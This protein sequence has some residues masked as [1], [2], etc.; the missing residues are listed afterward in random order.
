MD[1]RFRLFCSKNAASELFFKPS[2][3]CTSDVIN[4]SRR[5]NFDKRS[6]FILLRYHRVISKYFKFSMPA[7]W[8]QHPFKRSRNVN[9]CRFIPPKNEKPLKTRKVLLSLRNNVVNVFGIR[10]AIKPPNLCIVFMLILFTSYFTYG[11]LYLMCPILWLL[12]EYTNDLR[13]RK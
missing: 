5:G 12:S 3:R 10:S 9:F 11:V 2:P 4:V 1:V 7:T 13:F 8:N 6:P